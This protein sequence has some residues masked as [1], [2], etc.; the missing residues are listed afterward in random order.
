MR[1]MN[2]TDPQVYI[3]GVLN[4]ERRMVSKTITLMES[5]LAAHQ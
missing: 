4:Q 1:N 2:S 5:S 3:D